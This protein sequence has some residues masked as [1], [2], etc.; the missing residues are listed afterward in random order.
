MLKTDQDILCGTEAEI[1]FFHARHHRS[2]NC[3]LPAFARG[4]TSNISANGAVASSSVDPVAISNFA[5]LFAVQLQQRTK[6][7]PPDRG[8]AVAKTYPRPERWDPGAF[9]R[10]GEWL[11]L[12]RQMDPGISA[13]LPY[14]PA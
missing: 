9:A 1:E 10:D 11:P 14:R 7:A 4:R 3:V 8:K 13:S 2:D 12:P 5:E 6:L